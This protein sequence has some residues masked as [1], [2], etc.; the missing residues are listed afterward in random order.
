MDESTRNDIIRMFYSRASQRRIAK[1][2]AVGRKTVA[3][4]I[5]KHE[6]ARTGAPPSG[7]AVD[8]G[9]PAHPI[10]TSNGSAIAIPSWRRRDM[11]H[12]VENEKR[13]PSPQ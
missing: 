6:Q 12:S 11:A 1:K 4:V 9:A 7:V 3:D 5:A 10:A 8:A 2:L 13:C